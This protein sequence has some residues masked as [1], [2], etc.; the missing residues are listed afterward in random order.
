MTPCSSMVDAITLIDPG[1]PNEGGFE[2]NR[3]FT[4]ITSGFARNSG[5]DPF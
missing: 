2:C 5:H 1:E 3:L 4:I